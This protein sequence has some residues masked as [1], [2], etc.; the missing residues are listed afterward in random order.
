MISSSKELVLRIKEK[1]AKEV[2][3]LPTLKFK[4]KF[5]AKKLKNKLVTFTDVFSIFLRL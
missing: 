4:Y 2:T 1:M 3:L 5:Y